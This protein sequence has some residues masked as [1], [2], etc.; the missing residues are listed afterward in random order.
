MPSAGE[1]W[2][3][4][5]NKK[6]ILIET[7]NVIFTILSMR[8]ARS[9]VRI[10]VYTTSL[11]DER[12]IYANSLNAR[13]VCISTNSTRALRVQILWKIEQYFSVSFE[14]LFRSFS[15][16]WNCHNFLIHRK[17]QR[18]YQVV[19][20]CNRYSYT[21]RGENKQNEDCVLSVGTVKSCRDS[22]RAG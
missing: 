15:S 13:F 2:L 3:K 4:I 21:S 16:A 12:L 6:S 18:S 1:T 11:H 8:Q 10:S 20:A 17:D 5:T 9:A 19:R 7:S 14:H 22:I